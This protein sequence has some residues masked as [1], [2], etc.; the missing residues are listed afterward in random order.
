MVYSI[1]QSRLLD[2]IDNAKSRVEFLERAISERP[3]DLKMIVESEVSEI[4]G[5]LK[6][7]ILD[8]IKRG[9]NIK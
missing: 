7:D 9:Y 6:S 8:D 5:T 2:V 4:L 3:D 1:M